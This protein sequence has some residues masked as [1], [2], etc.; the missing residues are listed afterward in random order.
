MPESHKI[1]EQIFNKAFL[2]PC[3]TES[4]E[5]KAYGPDRSR[6]A[7]QKVTPT[8]VA[9]SLHTASGS[10][11][12]PSGPFDLGREFH[13]GFYCDFFFFFFLSPGVV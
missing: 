10:G 4:V 13:P 12:C 6:S 2:L 8:T 5:Q 9:S 11:F 7:L 1:D 3:S